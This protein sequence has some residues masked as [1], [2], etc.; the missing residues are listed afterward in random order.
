MIRKLATVTILTVLILISPFNFIDAEDLATPSSGQQSITISNQSV[1]PND[2]L[3]YLF[4]RVREKIGLL[5]AFT[6]KNKIK[7]Y[8]NLVNVRLAEL[9][10]IVE[11]KNMAYFEQ[12]TNRYFTV[13]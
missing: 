7:I 12:T 9:K 10:Y 4:K 13:D 6:D 5:F 1:N 2:G 11:N 3:N 8:K